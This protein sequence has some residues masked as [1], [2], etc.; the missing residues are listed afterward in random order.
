M[1]LQLVISNQTN[2]HLNVAVEN[3]LV[4]CDAPDTITLYLWKNHRT[5][6]IGQNQ[7]PYAECDV[8]LLESEGGYLMRRRTGGGA[9]YHDDGNIN[10]SFVVPPAHYDQL[11]QFRVL[12]KAVESYG[13][14]CE[15]S[16]RNDVLCDGRKFS[17]N[18]FSRGTHQ[19][20]HHGTILIAGNV[21]DMRR[22]LK[23]KP[24]KL[25]RHG[26]ASVRSRVVNLSELAAVTSD[27]IV[28]RLVDAFEQE[29]G[30]QV[31]ETAFDQLRTLPA[32]QRLYD[33]FAS[34]EWRFARWRSFHAE[35][36]GSFD[37]G[38]VELSLVVDEASRTITDIE[39]STDCLMVSLVDELRR[40]LIGA[41]SVSAPPLDPSLQPEL[42]QI[43]SD[44]D[45]LIF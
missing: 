25:S 35:R 27:N 44:I 6:V 45:G 3:Y 15:L 11:R 22:Y 12:M 34:D 4:S 40:H 10:F 29:Y 19:Y 13:L 43:I 39:V 23:V 21:D 33:E 30:G 7:N 38:E 5:V 20:L 9:V 32:V 26:V 36:H 24:S 17:G 8:E 16:G 18:A 14:H 28:P 1:H 2:P 37:W 31:V 41:S 42:A